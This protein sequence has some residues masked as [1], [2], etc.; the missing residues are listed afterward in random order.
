MHCNDCL[1]LVE[2]WTTDKKIKKLDLRRD[3]ARLRS[4][5]LS[6]SFR[7]TDFEFL[8]PTESPDENSYK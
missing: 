8:I 4:L 1:V 3:S 6:R 2:C 5:R 7:V